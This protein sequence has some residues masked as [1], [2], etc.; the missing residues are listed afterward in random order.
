MNE[1]HMT[2][3][4]Y[5]QRRIT[6]RSRKVAKSNNAAGYVA[7]WPEA[8]RK[9][10]RNFQIFHPPIKRPCVAPWKGKFTQ[11]VD[12]PTKISRPLCRQWRGFSDRKIDAAFG[13]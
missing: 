9:Y 8:V 1:E 4:A 10:W 12:E 5:L 2:P 6:E 11:W 13:D 7:M 3:G